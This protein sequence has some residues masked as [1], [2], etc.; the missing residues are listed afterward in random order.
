MP[1]HPEPQAEATD[2]P[3]VI[4]LGDPDAIPTTFKIQLPNGE[5]ITPTVLAE[6]QTAAHQMAGSRGQ[7][8]R[9]ALREIGTQLN[10]IGGLPLM[11]AACYRVKELCGRE[12]FAQVQYAWDGIGEW[13]P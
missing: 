3:V 12:A 2:D 7:E 9:A 6:L 10:D 4:Q 11:Q 1:K 8:G 5:D 13:R